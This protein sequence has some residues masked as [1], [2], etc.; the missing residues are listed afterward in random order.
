MV[1]RCIDISKWFVEDDGSDP[2]ELYKIM[3]K[4]KVAVGILL[5]NDA[6]L[7]ENNVHERTI[8]HK[9]GEY[10]QTQFPEWYVDC[11]YNRDGTESKKLETI[12][13]CDEARKTELVV[14]DIII[15]QRVKESEK[16]NNYVIIEVK[17]DDK[18]PDCDIKKLELFTSDPKFN[19]KFGLFIKFKQASTPE[20]RLFK[21]GCEDKD[22]FKN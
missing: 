16:I 21:N 7:L 4:V 11:E 10:L 18:K 12:R 2:N 9:L 3:E 6:W 19:Y 15:H 22:F 1:T 8:T 17:T 5:K 13:E 20:Y 14:P